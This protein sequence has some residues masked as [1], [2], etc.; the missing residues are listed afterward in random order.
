MRASPGVRPQTGQIPI[1]VAGVR[2]VVGLFAI[3]ISDMSD[4]ECT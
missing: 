1:G 3:V 4:F 2:L